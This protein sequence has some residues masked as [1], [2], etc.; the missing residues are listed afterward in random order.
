MLPLVYQREEI[1]RLV[2]SP[3]APG[4]TFSDA[5]RAFWRTSPDRQRWPCMP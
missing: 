4:E 3:R 5:D 2:L 1:G